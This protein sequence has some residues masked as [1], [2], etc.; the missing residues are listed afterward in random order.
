[1]QINGFLWIA[2]AAGDLWLYI[3]ECPFGWLAVTARL[4]GIN[5]RKCLRGEHLI[6]YVRESRNNLYDHSIY[7]KT[8]GMV[9]FR[10]S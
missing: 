6:A 1:M 7:E 3:S 5:L 8:T 9:D 4:V 10:S 2:S